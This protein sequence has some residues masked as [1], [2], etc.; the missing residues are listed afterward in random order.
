MRSQEFSGGFLEHVEDMT[1]RSPPRTL[2]QAKLS[3][4]FGQLHAEPAAFVAAR[5]R[6]Q[7]AELCHLG[8]PKA[9]CATGARRRDALVGALKHFER[10]VD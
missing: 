5:T 4:L 7:L 1:H 8:G 9:L 2:S 3:R 6:L 10:V